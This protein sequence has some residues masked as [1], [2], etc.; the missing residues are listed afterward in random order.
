MIPQ[1]LA[2]RSILYRSSQS[3]GGREEE[4]QVIH[5]ISLA[6]ADDIIVAIANESNFPGETSVPRETLGVSFDTRARA[7]AHIVTEALLR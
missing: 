1:T 2:R 3:G 4:E 5:R 7:R 6:K